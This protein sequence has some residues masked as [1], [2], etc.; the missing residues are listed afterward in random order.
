VSANGDVKPVGIRRIGV[1]PNRS[2]FPD[3]AKSFPD[4]RI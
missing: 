4:R 1:D 2:I 3:P